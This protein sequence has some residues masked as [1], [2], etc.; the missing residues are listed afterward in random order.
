MCACLPLFMYSCTLVYI[1]SFVHPLPSSLLSFL[2]SILPS[3]LPSFLPYI[4]ILPFLLLSLHGSLLP[5]FNSF[6]PFFFPLHLTF[7]SNLS[8]FPFTYYFAV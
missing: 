1:L 4:H 7:L 5:T 8:P 6:L 2:S 3:F